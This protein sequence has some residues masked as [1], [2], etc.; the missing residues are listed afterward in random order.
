MFLPLY[1]SLGIGLASE[2][3]EDEEGSLEGLFEEEESEEES[4][5]KSTSEGQKQELAEQVVEGSKDMYQNVEDSEEMELPAADEASLKIAAGP[6]APPHSSVDGIEIFSARN[7]M[8][9]GVSGLTLAAVSYSR[10]VTLHSQTEV[11]TAVDFDKYME[12]QRKSATAS[13]TFLGASAVGGA[14]LSFSI[15]SYFIKKDKSQEEQG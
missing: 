14:A 1:M 12:L 6:E 5:E 4:E 10:M 15:Y 2:P 3:E 7:M 8:I 13:K 11:L 9:V